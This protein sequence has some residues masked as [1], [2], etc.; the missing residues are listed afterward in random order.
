MVNAGLII[1]YILIGL[2]ALAAIILPLIQATGNPG[3][4]KKMGI[5]F[6][7]M[8]V[9]FAIC[10]FLAGSDTLGTSDVTEG[11]SKTVGAGLIMFYVLLIGAICTIVYTEFHKLTK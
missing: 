5:S 3:S 11:A 4:L 7:G 9:V 1:S 6:G 2:C 8:L 10:Y